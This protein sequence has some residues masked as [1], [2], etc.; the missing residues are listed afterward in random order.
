MYIVRTS[1]R[2]DNKSEAQVPVARRMEQTQTESAMFKL[3]L[4]IGRLAV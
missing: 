4:F 3:G 2:N 1:G